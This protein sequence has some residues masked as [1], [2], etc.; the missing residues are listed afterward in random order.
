MRGRSWGPTHSPSQVPYWAIGH[1]GGG[2]KRAPVP[3]AKRHVNVRRI[4]GVRWQCMCARVSG[5]S[6]QACRVAPRRVLRLCA[7]RRLSHRT[8]STHP[9]TPTHIASHV[10]TAT[11]TTAIAAVAAAAPLAPACPGTPTDCMMVALDAT[12]GLLRA[13]DLHPIMALSGPNYGPNMGTDV[14]LRW[15]WV[16]WWE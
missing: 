9:S 2:G 1:R 3:H 5:V 16:H 7:C 4:H 8:L 12:K 11:T 6:W 15:V 10:H 13:L 14:L